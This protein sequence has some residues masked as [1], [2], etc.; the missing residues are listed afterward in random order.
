MQV[1]NLSLISLS[2]PEGTCSETVSMWQCFRCRKTAPR[3]ERRGR[4]RDLPRWQT[5]KSRI[6]VCWTFY[7]NRIVSK[8]NASMAHTLYKHKPMPL[9]LHLP[10]PLPRHSIYISILWYLMS[11]FLRQQNK[12]LCCWCHVEWRWRSVCGMHTVLLS[13]FNAMPR[14]SGVVVTKATEQINCIIRMNLSRINEPNGKVNERKT[15]TENENAHCIAFPVRFR[16]RKILLL[17]SHEILNNSIPIDT[18]D[19]CSISIH[20]SSNTIARHMFKS[21][22]NGTCTSLPLELYCICGMM[23]LCSRI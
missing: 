4:R 13:A 2:K 10:L 17:R 19:F 22:Y 11:F 3:K 9:H 5:A 15:E 18:N 8:L 20:S 7:L 1:N 14:S 12:I 6:C 16:C 23:H 21:V